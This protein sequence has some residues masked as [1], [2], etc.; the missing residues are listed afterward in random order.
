MT[1][2]VPMWRLFGINK[3]QIN[4][5]NQFGRL[6]RLSRLFLGEALRRQFAQFV[7][8]EWQELLRC[9]R[10]AAVDGIQYLGDVVH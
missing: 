9:V 6:Q 4:F 2:A 8:N 7:I 10:I 3:S 1:A 5:V